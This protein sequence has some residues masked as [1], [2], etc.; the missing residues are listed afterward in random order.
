MIKYDF[1]PELSGWGN[2]IDHSPL[3]VWWAEKGWGMGGARETGQGSQERCLNGELHLK[4]GIKP[5]S[6]MAYFRIEVS[7][8]LIYFWFTD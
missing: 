1:H 7:H 4:Y 3:A 2:R 6:A 5:S 8:A